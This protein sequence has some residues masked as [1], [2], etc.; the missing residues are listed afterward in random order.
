MSDGASPGGALMVVMTTRSRTVSVPPSRPRTKWAWQLACLLLTHPIAIQPTTARPRLLVV[1]VAPPP[2]LHAPVV[3]LQEMFRGVD[4]R[5]RREGANYAQWLL[6]Q[7]DVLPEYALFVHGHWQAWHQRR[8]LDELVRAVKALIRALE[9]T[10]CRGDLYASI[11]PVRHEWCHHM[12]EHTEF[13]QT[14][15]S[16]FMRW[17]Y[18]ELPAPAPCL[19]SESSA[20]FVVSR[21]RIRAH[22]RAFYARLYN[23]TQACPPYGESVA[24]TRRER[25]FHNLLEYSWHVIFGQPALDGAAMTDTRELFL[26][27]LPYRGACARTV[28]ALARPRLPAAE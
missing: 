19:Q 8:S 10:P 20:Q 1:S 21:R 22:P 5:N 25:C 16:T 24:P 26:G 18:P 9:R 3:V 13:G 15:N 12:V 23:Y 11:T 28:E 4:H 27:L 14:L 2:P 6:E 7:Y 17:L